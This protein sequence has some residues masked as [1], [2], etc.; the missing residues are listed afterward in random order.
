MNG[1]KEPKGP[2]APKGVR[3]PHD[4][5]IPS[6][7]HLNLICWSTTLSVSEC[8]ST[9]CLGQVCSRRCRITQLPVGIIMNFHER[10]L[11]DGIRRHVLRPVKPSG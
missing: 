4:L 2:K 1:S 5:R 8:R 7:S 11:R 3:G 10:H 9:P 6:P